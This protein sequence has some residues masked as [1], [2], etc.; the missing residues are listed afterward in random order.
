[1]FAALLPVKRFDRSKERLAEF[2][3]SQ[4][5]TLLAQA[6]FEDVW[7]A[8]RQARRAGEGLDQ[9]LAIT[10]EP[11]VI[12]RCR[13]EGVPYL[14][15][16]EQR[17]HSDSVNRATEWALSLGITSLLSVPIDTPAVT[18]A[19]ILAVLQLRS[20][21]AVIVVP[22]A[23]GTGTNALL[24]TPPNAIAPHFGPGSCR[25]H[26]EEAGKKVLPHLVFPSPGLSNDIDTPED[27]ERFLASE[28]QS[29]RTWKLV[30]RFLRAHRKVVACP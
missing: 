6:M 10:A 4:E 9:L 17:S 25:L 2:L 30:R 27:L 11:Y 16:A 3:S 14:E 7:A 12:A 13:R 1:M 20:R 23:D 5:R 8:L 28:R 26:T 15:E 21:F 19:E 24:R 18:A 22:S 29:S